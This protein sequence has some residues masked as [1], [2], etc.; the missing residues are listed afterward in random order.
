MKLV[1]KGE[2]LNQLSK[3]KIYSKFIPPLILFSYRDFAYNPNS[4]FKLI[5]KTFKKKIIIRSCSYDEDQI[6]KSNA[7]KYESYA[8]IEPID[9][10]ALEKYIKLIYQSY[11]INNSTG[12]ILIQEMISNAKYSGVIT[13]ALTNGNVNYFE[14]NYSKG[15]NTDIVTSGKK[16]VKNLILFKNY[17]LP[18]KFNFFD[19]LINITNKLCE[20]FKNKLLDIEF[21]ITVNNELKIFQVRPLFINPIKNIDINEHF[22]L[23]Q[24][25]SKKINKLKKN[26]KFLK[27]NTSYYGVMPDWNPAEIIGLKPKNLAFTIYKEIIT[28]QIWADQRYH[29]GFQKLSDTPLMTRFLGTPYID[30][31]INFNSWV[32]ENL[33]SELQKKIVTYYLKK[34]RRNKNL[35]DKIESKIIFSSYVFDTNKKVNKLK[36]NNFSNYEILL[37]KKSLKLI[38]QKAIENFYV[39]IDKINKLEKKQKKVLNSNLDTIQKIYYLNKN[40]KIYGTLPFAGLARNAFIAIDFLNSLLDESFISNNDKENI[41]ASIDNVSSNLQSDFQKLN[42]K[43]FLKKYGHLRPNTYDIESKT[44]TDAYEKYFSKFAN[45]TKSIIKKDNH[46]NLKLEKIYENKISKFLKTNNFHFKNSIELFDYIKSAITYREKSKFIFTKSLTDIFDQI[47]AIGNRIN[48]KTSDLAHLDYNLIL[49]KYSELN[50]DSLRSIFKSNIRM[51]KIEYTKNIS[52]P[53]PELIFNSNDIFC[54]ENAVLT[55]NYTGTN[56]VSGEIYHL[57]NLNKDINLNDKIV[58]IKNADPGYDFIFNKNIKALITC[59]GGANSHMSI[60]CTEFKLTGI[61]GIGEIKYNN[62]LK[63]TN[64]YIDPVK[65]FYKLF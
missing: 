63:S 48:I 7:G 33:S 59:Y 40:L 14:I 3:S 26:H 45:I 1:N 21:C 36:K 11:Q 31:R 42:K 56:P 19:Q 37:I 10:N 28:N 39:D 47:S 41:L 54:Y 53:L 5:K 17:K 2:N 62:I 64:I 20:D 49:E 61:I 34:F 16:G 52:I 30:M 15:S 6:L 50:S 35:H 23:L 60:R 25:L 43:N 58:L 22:L 46:F 57:T 65:N 32:P 55:G 13:T 29:Y 51:N 18:K 38:T 8:N 44:Y 12:L 9:I 4:F 24:N 27:G